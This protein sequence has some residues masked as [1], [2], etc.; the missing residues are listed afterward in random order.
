MADGGVVLLHGIDGTSGGALVPRLWADVHEEYPSFSLVHGGGA[1]M[2]VIG[3]PGEGVDSLVKAE[4]EEL[5]S[6]RRFLFGA[7]RG[8]AA[9]ARSQSVANLERDGDTSAV[10]LAKALDF[11]ERVDAERHQYRERVDEL[12][13]ELA[14][15]GSAP[16]VDDILLRGEVAELRAAHAARSVQI[17]AI[18]RSKSWRLTYP[19]RVVWSVL[20]GKGRSTW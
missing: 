17:D 15:V 10:L 7:G 20:R 3:Q 6:L 9:L 5:E 8:I 16:A 19:I 14:R 2:F 13:A 12:E 1:G 18:L 4:G 11:I